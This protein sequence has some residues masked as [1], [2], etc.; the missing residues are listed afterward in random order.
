MTCA[1]IHAIPP[2]PTRSRSE[3]RRIRPPEA[4]ARASR[5]PRRIRRPCRGR[6]RSAT[7]SISEGRGARPAKAAD[8]LEEQADELDL[9]TD[10]L[11]QDVEETRAD[12]ERKR[13]DPNVPGAPPAAADES[14]DQ[15]RPSGSPT[16]KRE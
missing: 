9:R 2:V 6:A 4:R 5:T 7:R 1:R 11:Q 15:E 14:E 3:R 16:D 10:R 12:W 13:A 8:E